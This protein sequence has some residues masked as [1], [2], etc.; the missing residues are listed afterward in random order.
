MSSMGNAAST[1]L[2]ICTVAFDSAP[3]LEANRQLLVRL[4]PGQPLYVGKTFRTREGS[5]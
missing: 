1:D 4:N 3:W 2:T 5:R